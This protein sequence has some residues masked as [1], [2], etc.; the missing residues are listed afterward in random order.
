MFDAAKYLLVVSTSEKSDTAT[1]E[2]RDAS[3]FSIMP[4]RRCRN[5]QA[6]INRLQA[7]KMQNDAFKYL[8]C[9]D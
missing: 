8:V 3:I 2:Q 9:K 7:Y 6:K 1:R 5:V 4:F